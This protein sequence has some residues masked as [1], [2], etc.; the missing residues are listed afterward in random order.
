MKT[1]IDKIKEFESGT[2]TVESFNT[3]FNNCQ[4]TDQD[5]DSVI[6]IG[7]PVSPETVREV[8]INGI[9]FRH[10]FKPVMQSIAPV[11]GDIKF[12]NEYVPHNK[13]GVLFTKD[14]NPSVKIVYNTENIVMTEKEMGLEPI[15]YFIL[16]YLRGCENPYHTQQEIANKLNLV[17]RTIRDQLHKMVELNIITTSKDISNKTKTKILIKEEWQ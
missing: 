10:D 14:N 3:I 5:L 7:T 1:L 6:T 8:T 15:H 13:R 2:E 4:I 12:W 16:Q 11:E 9:T 17:V